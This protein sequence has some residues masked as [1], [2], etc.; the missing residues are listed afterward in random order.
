[1]RA[2]ASLANR[3]AN[4]SVFVVREKVFTLRAMYEAIAK[5]DP[6]HVVLQF[7]HKHNGASSSRDVAPSLIVERLSE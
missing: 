6:G 4:D 2:L 7:A 1:M 3:S 5:V